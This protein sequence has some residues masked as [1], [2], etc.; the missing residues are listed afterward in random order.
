M[1]ALSVRNTAHVS[2]INIS[3]LSAVQRYGLGVT[4]TYANC[5]TLHCS[6]LEFTSCRIALG[7][8]S[9]E[10]PLLKQG[11]IELYCALLRNRLDKDSGQRLIWAAMYCGLAT[12]FNHSDAALNNQYMLLRCCNVGL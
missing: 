9:A 10:K 1:T 8:N 2:T 12:L 5:G 11:K 3:G 6:K 7:L 4:S